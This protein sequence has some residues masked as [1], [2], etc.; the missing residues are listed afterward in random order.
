MLLNTTLED[1]VVAVNNHYSKWCKGANGFTKV[2]N[3]EIN[4]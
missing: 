1:P 2:G 3:R 4:S